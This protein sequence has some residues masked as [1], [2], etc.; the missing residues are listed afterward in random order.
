MDDAEMRGERIEGEGWWKK[1]ERI[2]S[3]GKRRERGNERPAQ[4][5]DSMTE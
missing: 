5:I 1:R 4:E 3:E 2:E